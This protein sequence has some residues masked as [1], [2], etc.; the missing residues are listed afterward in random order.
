MEDAQCLYIAFKTDTFTHC[1]LTV[2]YRQLVVELVVGK[3]CYFILQY[4]YGY[5][6]TVSKQVLCNDTV[7]YNFHSI[8][9][10]QYHLPK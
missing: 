7:K 1:N 3:L 5:L 8:I 4:N 10:I 9:L 2:T 6:N